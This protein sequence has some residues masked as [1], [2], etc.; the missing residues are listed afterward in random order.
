MRH[1]F[2]FLVLSFLF[3]LQSFAA[4]LKGKLEQLKDISGVEE[5]T[6]EHY[7]EKYL[8]RISQPVD[9]R[10]PEAGSFTQRVVVCH[11]GTDRPTVIVTEG[12]GGRYALS[13]SYR[14]ELSMLLNANVVFVEHRYFLES[15]PESPD[16]DCLTAENSA[17]DLHH[18]TSTFRALYP[19][20]WMSTGISKGG[21]TTLIYRTFFPD[22]VDFSIPYVAPLCRGV[23]DGRHEGFLRKVGT[24]AERKKVEAFQLETL[25]RKEAMLPLLEAFCRE[26]NLTFRISAAEVLDYCVLEYSFA[27]WQWGTPAGSIP[28]P[29]SEDKTLFDHLMN[30]SGP[31][32]FAENQPNATFFVQAAKELGYYGYDTRPFQKYLTIPHAAG[33]LKQL[34]LPPGAEHTA[35]DPALY[36]K[37]YRFLKENDPKIIFIYGELDPWSAAHAPVFKK[38]KNARFFFQPRGSHRARI[39]NMPEKTKE[40]IMKQIN[41][42]L[43]NP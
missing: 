5:L 6:S 10:R 20:R 14:E 42:W 19:G 8:M 26:K 2:L 15:T 1:T 28:S 41:E 36:Q 29:A 18:V 40:K 39:S 9:H 32:Y 33:Y 7:A 24:R 34:M 37:I 22:D 17:F 21:Q 23:E 38:K 12:Y 27:F 16:W 11:V 13:P 25:R 3:S 31:D 4:E 30:I 43:T 35:F